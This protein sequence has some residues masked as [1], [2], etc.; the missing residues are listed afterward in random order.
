M[1]KRRTWS[2]RLAVT[3]RTGKSF[4]VRRR[5]SAY[6]D[7]CRFGFSHGGLFL[8]GVLEGTA[9]PYLAAARGLFFM[10]AY[11]SRTTT[12]GRDMAGARGLWRATGMTDADFDKPIIA[13]ANSF[14]QVVPAAST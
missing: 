10:P 8:P 7:V 4:P 1:E 11:R 14:T 13:I 6:S 9:I 3:A 2:T 5:T 12:H